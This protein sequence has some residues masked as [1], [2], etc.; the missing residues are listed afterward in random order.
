MKRTLWSV[1]ECAFAVHFLELRSL[2]MHVVVE[3]RRKHLS[4]W[5]YE[6]VFVLM[7]WHSLSQKFYFTRVFRIAKEAP[8]VVEYEIALFFFVV[9]FTFPKALFHACFCQFTCGSWVRPT[10]SCFRCRL[11]VLSLLCCSGIRASIYRFGIRASA[12]SFLRGW[13]SSC[14]F[15]SRNIH[16][17]QS[18][19]SRVFLPMATFS[20]CHYRLEA[21]PMLFRRLFWSILIT[22]TARSSFCTTHR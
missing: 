22:P 4:F 6:F 3:S 1:C 15:W 16:F 11:E 18:V 8:V 14:L 12:R 17:S 19:I 7:S 5:K 9:T 2:A 21:L 13:C 10:F 20:V